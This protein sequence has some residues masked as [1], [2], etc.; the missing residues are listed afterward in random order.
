VTATIRHLTAADRAAWLTMLVTLFPDEPLTELDAHVTTVLGT[1]DWVAFAA[2]APDGDLIG[3]IE[4][5][6]RNYAEGCWTSPVPFVEAL[7]VA[8]G[9]RRQGIARALVDAAIAWGQSRGRSEIGSDTQLWNAASQAV[10][11]ALGFSEADRV[12]AYRM[13]I[14]SR[15]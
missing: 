9:S 3:L 2:L 7:W 12:V 13:D 15:Q 1:D 8:A 10:H 4:I 11:R 6:E 5:F 14:G